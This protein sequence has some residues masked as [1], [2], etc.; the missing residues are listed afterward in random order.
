VESVRSASRIVRARRGRLPG[1]RHLLP[2]PGRRWGLYH[3]VLRR[4]PDVRRGL[5]E[6][7]RLP[8]RAVGGLLVGTVHLRR[9]AALRRGGGRL[10]L[11]GR[12]G[13]RDRPLDVRT[14]LRHAV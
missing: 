12:P 14:R 3:G 10:H 6:R 7:R 11:P 2:E 9:F 1:G 5:R 13:V 8:G 4:V